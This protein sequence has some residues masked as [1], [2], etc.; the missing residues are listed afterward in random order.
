MSST[1]GSSLSS[2]R[3][4][5]S[6]ISTRSVLNDPSRLFDAR[7]CL[8]R[9]SRTNRD[10]DRKNCPDVRRVTRNIRQS[11]KFPVSLDGSAALCFVLRSFDDIFVDDGEPRVHVYHVYYMRICVSY[12]WEEGEKER[13]RERDR[14]NGEGRAKEGRNICRPISGASLLIRSFSFFNKFFVTF[15]LSKTARAQ[16]SACAS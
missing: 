9:N 5:V 2:R 6:R 14:E 13:K 8:S 7:R 4:F 15:G 3:I 1:I 16:R 12:T 11:P 10:S